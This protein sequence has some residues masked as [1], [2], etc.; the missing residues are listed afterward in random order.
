MKKVLLTLSVLVML[1]AC[2]GGK[3]TGSTNH[4]NPLMQP[5]TLEMQAP[6]FSKITAA[7]YLPAFEEGIKIHNAEIDSI[8]NNPEAP[9]FDNTIVAMEKAGRL[10]NRTS[11]IFFGIAGADATDD[12][13]KI[14]EEITPKLSAHSDG[15]Y[16]NDKLFQRVKAVYDNEYTKL[17]GEQAMLLKVYYDR[18]L[19]SGA[20]LTPENKE[21]L[22]AINTELAQLSTKF[23][24]VLKDATNAVAVFV[25]N[26]DM[27]KGLSEDDIAALGKAAEKDGKAGQYKIEITNTTQQ[28]ILAQLENRD[29]RKQV[30]EASMHRCDHG[31]FSTDSLIVRM[32]ELKADKAQL[33]GFKTFAAWKLQDQVAQTPERVVDF[34][35]GLV[36]NYLPKAKADAAMLEEYA[37]KTE[38]ADFKLEAWDWEYYAAKLRQEKFGI[39]DSEINQ[40]FVLDSVVKNGVFYAA[41]KLYGM[42][43]KERTD[44]PTYQ[45]NVHVYDV[46]DADGQKMAIFY[47]DYYRR[48]TKSGGAWMSNWVEQS[49]LLGTKPVIYNVMNI[50]K[51][52]DGQ[53]TLISWDHVTT[54]FHEFGHALHGLFASQEYPT[55]SGTSVARDFVEMPSQFNEHWASYPEIFDHFARNYKTGEPMPKELKDK[56]MASLDFLPSYALGENMAA[57]T[58]DMAWHMI[59]PGQKVGNVDEFEKT[60]LEAMQLLNPQ[61]PPRYRSTYFRHIWSNEYSAGYYAYLWSE[62]MDQNA[63]DWFLKN[64][65]L[66]R[67]NGDR[68]RKILLSVGNTRDLNE[69]FTE[70]TGL[71]K[72]DVNALLRNRGILK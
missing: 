8:A 24:N 56:F 66:T 72:P 27:L 2:N 9:T 54:L 33:L 48:P 41:E 38:G 67:D 29:L 26:K 37:R 59:A 47:T 16:M 60:S 10:L 13:R 62:V 17:Q 53:P 40:Y 52:E 49:N 3:K 61:I 65:G 51:P 57:V 28:P 30:F 6:D 44:L 25:D 19:Q 5:S 20:L 68:L 42:T 39:N 34:I 55:L 45:D 7:D 11:L 31:E 63:Y 50:D 18:F 70:F 35:K 58:L 12:I 15:I 22:K 23:G 32:A 36:A 14:E 46:F 1:T 4:D 64:G 43:F 21:K 69:A 71:E